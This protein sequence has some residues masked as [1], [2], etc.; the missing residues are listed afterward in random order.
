MTDRDGRYQGKVVVVTGAS[1]GIGRATALAFAERGAVVVGVARREDRLQQ[2]A[3]E[4]RAHAPGSG[5]LAGDLAEQRF[6]EHVIEDTVQRHGRIDVLINNAAVPKHKQIYHVSSD[7]VEQ[8]T[9]INFL[10]TVWTTLAAIPPMLANGGGFIVNVSSFAAKVA[11]PREAVYAATKAA[12]SSFTE[13]LWNDLAGSN[14]HVGLIVPGPFDTEI[15]EKQEEPVA[16][17]GHKYPPE[18][19]VNAIFAAIEKRRFEQTVPRRSLGLFV[20]RG[21]R[22]FL[23]SLLRL[24]IRRMDPVPEEVIQRARSR[25]LDRAGQVG[26]SGQTGS[27]GSS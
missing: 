14:I 13:G 2:L 9:R 11:P 1:S 15:W 25:A 18:L 8:V 22:I 3:L 16:W 27:G 4:C 24:G 23:P 17:S 19:V 21:L 5:Y 20:A 26:Q 7:E 12:M 6:A 10:A